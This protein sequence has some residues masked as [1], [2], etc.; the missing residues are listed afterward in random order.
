[1]FDSYYAADYFDMLGDNYEEY[2]RVRE[3]CMMELNSP[4]DY[5]DYIGYYDDEYY[6]PIS[7]INV[8]DYYE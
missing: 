2:E 3:E 7:S 5:Y 1:M 6:V 8:G 4:E